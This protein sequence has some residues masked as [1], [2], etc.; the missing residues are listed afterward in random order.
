MCLLHK[1]DDRFPK[2]PRLPVET[3]AGYER[4]SVSGSR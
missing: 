2:Y 3:C 1:T 4:R